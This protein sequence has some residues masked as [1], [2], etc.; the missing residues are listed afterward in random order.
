MRAIALAILAFSLVTFLTL[1]LASSESIPF[2]SIMFEVVS[3]V[4]TVG[5]SMGDGGVRSLSALFSDIGKLVI[6]AGMILGRFGPL[7]IGL[8]SFKSAHRGYRYPES[9]V[10][11][12]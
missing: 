8:T 5:L 12:G 10:V 3:A 6:V 7:M 9:K 1:V 11:V 4:G 2:L